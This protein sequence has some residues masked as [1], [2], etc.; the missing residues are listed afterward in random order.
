MLNL[1]LNLS[2]ALATSTPS[3]ANFSEEH[4][5]WQVWKS[6]NYKEA[7]NSPTSF[8][9]AYSLDKARKGESLYLSLG[10]SRR[11][12][13]WQKQEPKKFFIKAEHLGEK[14]RIQVQGKT[15]QYLENSKGKRRKKIELKNGAIAE[16]V[17]GKRASNMWTYLYDPDQIKTFTG[18]EFYPFNQSAVVE[19]VFK[20]HES[21]FI[22]YKTVQGVPTKVNQVGTVSFKLHGKEFYLPAYNWQ[23]SGSRLRY[24][25][26]VYT[27]LTGGKET[28]G[29]GR[30]LVVDIEGEL[31]DKQKLTLDFNRSMN[32]FCAHSPFW[33]CPVGLQKNINVA[34]KAGEKLPK[35]KIAN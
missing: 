2:F 30:E 8:L 13:K 29:G 31:K 17:Y 4:T 33:H 26:M 19:G 5:Q 28:Y 3:V 15:I 25:A 1:I 16:V 27:D 23:E 14:I 10:N 6:K 32:F 35:R 22:S 18:F 20:K 24:I 21:R 11:T 7:L 12:T 34:V 9:N